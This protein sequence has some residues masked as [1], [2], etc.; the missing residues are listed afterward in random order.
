MLSHHQKLALLITLNQTA[1]RAQGGVMLR[2]YCKKC[3]PDSRCLSRLWN[4]LPCRHVVICVR[5][6]NVS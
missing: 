2:Q 5:H 6:S 1:A 4:V 3:L